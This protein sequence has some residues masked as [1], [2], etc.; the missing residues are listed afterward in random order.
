MSLTVYEAPLNIT[1]SDLEAGIQNQE[2]SGFVLVDLSEG[3]SGPN[4]VN[5][6]SFQPRTEKLGTVQLILTP[7]NLFVKT[8]DGYS[9][10][11]DIEKAFLQHT[12]DSGASIVLYCPIV[13][14]EGKD[15]SLAVARLPDA[16]VPISGGD[17]GPPFSLNCVATCFGYQDSGDKGVGAFTN[18]ATN[19]PYYT[20][21]STLVGVAVPIPILDQTL[22]GLNSSTVAQYTVG[23]ILN[24][25]SVTAPIVDVGPGRPVDGQHGLLAG[26]DGTLHALDMTCGLC[27]ALGVKYDANASSYTVTWWIQDSSGKPV[28]LKGL[29]AP[30]TLA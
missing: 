27:T 14:I 13:S 18:P 29:D 22:G 26:K 20:N 3:T 1:L 8:A 16:S 15:T 24:G 12:A 19:R 9:V 17:P 11:P 21:N 2:D 28:A 5:L 6:V 4:S 30:K 23:V 10:N 7:A 25:K